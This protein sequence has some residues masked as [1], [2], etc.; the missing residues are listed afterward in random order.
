ME[1]PVVL[2]PAQVNPQVERR[3]KS[4]FPISD[5]NN[6]G[7]AG[8]LTEKDDISAEDQGRDSPMFYNYSLIRF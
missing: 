5:V 7:D 8:D 4:V 6:W 1:H 3:F 2:H